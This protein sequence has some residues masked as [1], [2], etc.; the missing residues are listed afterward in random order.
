MPQ[1][2]DEDY[3]GR[4]KCALAGDNSERT[5]KFLLLILLIGPKGTAEREPAASH[6]SQREREREVYSGGAKR[7]CHVAP[8]QLAAQVTI[9]VNSHPSYSF[10]GDE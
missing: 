9:M 3:R 6:Q 1:T 2:R 5:S 7:M 4:G 8:R 10:R